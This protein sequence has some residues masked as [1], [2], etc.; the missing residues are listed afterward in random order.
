MVGFQANIPLAVQRNVKIIKQNG[1]IGRLLE[2]ERMFIPME[3]RI[4][5]IMNNLIILKCKIIDRLCIKDRGIE[6]FETIVLDY[7]AGYIRSSVKI[8]HLLF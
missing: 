8:F 5:L 3:S 2:K 7:D 4:S 6:G 1:D